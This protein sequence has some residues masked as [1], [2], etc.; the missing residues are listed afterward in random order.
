MHTGKQLPLLVL[1]RPQ[2]AGEQERGR[3]EAKY[4]SRL[5]YA[6]QWGKWVSYVGNKH[7]PGLRLYRYKEAFSFA[8]VRRFLQSLKAELPSPWVLDPFMGM[9]TTPYTAM[10]MGLPGIG[11]DKLPVAV[12]IAR[13]LI[14]LTRIQPGRLQQAFRHLR[15]RVASLEPAPIA[16]DVPII[17]RAF[18]EP[19]LLRLRQWKRA[20][21]TLEPP[22]KDVFWV[23][24]LA[25]LEPCS[26][27][28]KDGQFLR[29][30]PQKP[31]R[32]P[33]DALQEMVVRAEEDIHTLHILRA[34]ERWGPEP[35]LLE[36]DA[37]ALTE[38]PL[39]G[40][41]G[42]IITS[43]PYANRYDYTRTYSLELCFGFVR[44]FEELRRLRHAVLRS[45]IESRLD[46]EN[47]PPPHPAVAEIEE[48]L[49]K[50]D[51]NN[52]RIPIML[53]AYF[54]DM[55][56]VLGEMY[57]VLAPGGRVVMVVD[58]VRFEGEHVPVD[59][60]LSDLAEELGFQV[61]SILVARFKGN[62]SQQMKK[63]GRQPV[64][65]SI[66]LWRKPA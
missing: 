60:I 48:A 42:L 43:P 18:P 64:R 7:V 56:R 15:D 37:R 29:L 13:G 52:P 59:L 58:N 54:V 26:R 2:A 51:L 11:V 14:A 17:Q 55:K 5:Q 27:T 31:L 3:L 36:G 40:P 28:T 30:R 8:L 49:S 65:E 6:L 61:E 25:I 41:V 66:L 47:E 10:R 32:D 34:Q 1:E 38:L 50:K 19:I 21:A 12:A 35:L 33:D 20:I 24:F 63:Y 62:S 44:N 9:G 16:D 4:A 45:H 39:P 46:A 57:R 23:L 22:L 53:R